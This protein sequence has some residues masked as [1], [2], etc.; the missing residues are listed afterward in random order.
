MPEA[1]DYR[2]V[3]SISSTEVMARGAFS[4]I[5]CI[6]L[7]GKAR[8]RETLVSAIGKAL[9]SVIDGIRKASSPTTATA[10]WSNN[11]GTSQ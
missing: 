11:C 10:Y 2:A 6:L 4:T 3:R 5:E 1:Y 8:K 7:L 9:D